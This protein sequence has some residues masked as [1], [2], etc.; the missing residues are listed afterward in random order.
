MSLD[1]ENRP[2]D[3]IKKNILVI[4]D[5]DVIRQL[6]ND[7]LDMLGF[8][9]IL[10]AAPEEALEIYREQGQNIDLILMDMMMPGMN[11]E[12][13][14]KAMNEI[15]R[16]NR[17]IVLSGYS[18][19]DEVESMIREGAVGFIQKPVSIAKLKETIMKALEDEHMEEHYE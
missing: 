18:M 5:E 15:D 11:G 8:N 14:Y 6:L 1:S 19:A 16:N 4:D 12:Q 9:V 3:T 7:I 13:L 2:V 17:V 10:S